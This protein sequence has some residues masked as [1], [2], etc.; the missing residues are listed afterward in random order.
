MLYLSGNDAGKNLSLLTQRP[1]K[2]NFSSQTVDFKDRKTQNNYY[3]SNIINN[4]L[5]AANG[6]VFM[7]ESFDE[8][9]SINGSFSGLLN[10]G[11]NK[12]DMDVSI[13]FYELMPDCKYFCLT[14][15]LGAP[16]MPKTKGK[17]NC[18]DPAKKKTFHLMLPEWSANK[19][20]KAAALS[21]F[22]TSTSIPLKS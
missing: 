5:D 12:R 8:A 7:T 16:V 3:T 11:I 15:Y 18:F 13:A 17:D 6:L 21:S 9:F 19:S 10:A 14:N 2:I 22:L 4:S 20:V 1:K